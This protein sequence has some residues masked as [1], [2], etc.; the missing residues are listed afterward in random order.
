MNR[1]RAA[2]TIGPWLIMGLLAAG[3]WLTGSGAWIYVKAELAQVLLQKA[4]AGILDGQQQVK[5]WP[6]ADTWPVAR[7]V[8]PGLGIDHIVLEGAYGRTL[9]FGPSRVELQPHATGQDTTILTGHRDSHFRFLERLQPGETILVQKQTGEWQRY[10]VREAVVVDARTASIRIDESGEH[11]LLVTCYPFH[12]LIANT[13]L[14]YIVTADLAQESP[15]DVTGESISWRTS[16]RPS[17]P[18]SIS[19]AAQD[20]DQTRSPSVRPWLT[21]QPRRASAPQLSPVVTKPT[22]P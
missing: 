15:N 19:R 20:W 6:W 17:V 1:P 8:V 16:D 14:R 11:L 3:L 4:W 21:L 7:L 22:L 18:H 2:A 12:G 13:T 10:R 5:P 9:A